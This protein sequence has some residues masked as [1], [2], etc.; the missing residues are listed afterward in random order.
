MRTDGCNYLTHITD[1]IEATYNPHFARIDGC[2]RI[3][4]LLPIVVASI[5]TT[6]SIATALHRNRPIS[7]VEFCDESGMDLRCFAGSHRYF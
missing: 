3:G 5:A 1:S 6:R 7:Q 2:N 4:N